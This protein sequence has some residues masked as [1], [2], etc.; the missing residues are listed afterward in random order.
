MDDYQFQDFGCEP[1]QD[2]W[3]TRQANNVPQSWITTPNIFDWDTGFQDHIITNN[4]IPSETHVGWLNPVMSAPLGGFEL[5]W[6]DATL[7]DVTSYSST[8]VPEIGVVE[9]LVIQY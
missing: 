8:P 1:Y 2:D 4:Y 3:S 5:S 7:Q 6:D 9:R